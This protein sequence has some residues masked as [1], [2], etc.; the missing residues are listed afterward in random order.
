MWPKVHVLLGNQKDVEM[1]SSS[2]GDTS[3]TA[4]LE[5]SLLI[6]DSIKAVSL[7]VNLGNL[8]GLPDQGLFQT[9]V[10]N[11]RQFVR[12]MDH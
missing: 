5:I 4:P 2:Q 8:A 10:Y 3:V 9:Q 11:L 6:S 1:N 12:S 7:L